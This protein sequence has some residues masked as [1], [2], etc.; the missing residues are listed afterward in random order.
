M[1]FEELHEGDIL[2][3]EL[4]GAPT[5]GIVLFFDEESFV[6]LVDEEVLKFSVDLLS[7]FEVS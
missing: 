5:R 6:L 3:F 4:Y 1:K 7:H 2:E